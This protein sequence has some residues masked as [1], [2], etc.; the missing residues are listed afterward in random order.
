MSVLKKYLHRFRHTHPDEKDALPDHVHQS[1]SGIIEE[2]SSSY[3]RKT[4]LLMV[5]RN[6]RSNQ[7]A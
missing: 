6:L 5:V 1:L 2:E 3:S 7:D 4:L